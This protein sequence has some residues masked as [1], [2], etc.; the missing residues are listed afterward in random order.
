MKKI[1]LLLGILIY[2][3]GYKILA[4]DI[5]INDKIYVSGDPIGIKLNNGVEIV[6]T[7]GVQIDGKIYKP[8]DEAGLQ[9]GDKIIS[10]NNKKIEKSNDLLNA[11]KLSNGNSS[12]IKYERNNKEYISKIKPVFYNN[13]LSLG[14][15][16]KDSILGV[17]TLTYY[18]KEANIFGSLGHKITDDEF[19]SGDIYEATITDIIKPKRNQAGEKKATIENKKIGTIV[20]NTIT[21]VHGNCNSKINT[22]SMELLNFEI[23]ENAHLGAAEIWTC[24]NGNKVEKYDIEI[25]DLKEQKSKDIKGI[26]FEVVDPDLISYTGGIVQGMSGSP[27]VQDNKIIGA[28][29]HVSVSNPLNAFGIYIE[30]MFEDMGINVIK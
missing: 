15:Y 14:L 30:W 27:I 13:D 26:L 28:V 12:E 11:L 29:T 24:I 19:Y 3:I 20:E 16:V 23:R 17:G 18:V 7:F 1:I 5:N 2:L 25:T 4:Y 22:D 21:G 6:G 9:E 10:L 8:W